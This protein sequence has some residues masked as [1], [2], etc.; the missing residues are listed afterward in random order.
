MADASPRN[1]LLLMWSGGKD[2]TLVLDVLHSQSPRRIG[3]FLTTVVEGEETVRMH[4]TPLSLIERQAEAI[5]IPL[6]VVRLPPNASNDTYEAHLGQ[7]LAPLMKEGFSTVAVG[8]LF[9][10]DIRAYRERVLSKIGIRPLFPLWKR[11]TSWLA[12]HFTERGYQAIVTSVDTSQLD[13]TFVGRSYDKSFLRDLPDDVDPCGENGAFHTFVTDGPP[14]QDHVSV[15][16]GE[17]YEEGR[18]R[19]VKLRTGEGAEAP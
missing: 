9:L 12:R 8:D 1:G 3:A 13:P 5:G 19:Y 18:M 15:S 14:F 11:D 6:H 4:G 16:L 10:E 17:S 7:A 2:A